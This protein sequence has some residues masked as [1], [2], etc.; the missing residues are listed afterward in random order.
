MTAMMFVQVQMKTQN[1]NKVPL[2]QATVLNVRQMMA[3]M[4]VSAFYNFLFD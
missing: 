1:L 2:I 4:K 3:M